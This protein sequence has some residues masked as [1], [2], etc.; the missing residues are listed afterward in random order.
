MRT[1]RALRRNLAAGFSMLEVLIAA[2]ILTGGLLSLAWVAAQMSVTTPRGGWM[3]TA[4]I[5]ASEK[6]ED[7]N[8]YTQTDPNISFNGANTTAGS[9]DPTT[10]PTDNIGGQQVDYWDQ[11]QISTGNGSMDETVSSRDPITGKQVYTTI[12]HKPDGTVQVLPPAA[13]LPAT[14]GDM[15]VFKRNWLIEKD[16][17]VAGNPV[18]G[19]RRVT[20]LVTLQSQIGIKGTLPITFQTSM[21]RP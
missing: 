4:V 5:L 8:K 11:V 16:P 3:T 19:I 2:L 13:A 15:I 21:V 6:L 20:V 1:H 12:E 14:T 17:V 7:L 9:L 18:V 10:T